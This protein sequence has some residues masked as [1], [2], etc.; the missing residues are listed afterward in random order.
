MRVIYNEQFWEYHSCLKAIFLADRIDEYGNVTWA[1]DEMIGSYDVE[2][3]IYKND[4][5]V[6]MHLGSFYI[7]EKYRGKGYAHK[8]MD[9]VLEIAKI[10][11]VQEIELKI[12]NGNWVQQFY[13]KYGFV[14]D[15]ENKCDDDRYSWMYKKMEI[16]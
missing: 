5:Y 15:T 16:F 9:S 12:H 1:V 6:I 13:E 3:R 4:T 7:N 8:M 11:D 14:L 10:N 2:S